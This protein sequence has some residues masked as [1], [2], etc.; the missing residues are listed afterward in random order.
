MS[1]MSEISAA[2]LFAIFCQIDE[3]AAKIWVTIMDGASGDHNGW[4]E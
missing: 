3:K 1:L 4:S 2:F